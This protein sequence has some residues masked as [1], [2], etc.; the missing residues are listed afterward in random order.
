VTPLLIKVDRV[1]SVD[2]AQVLA[3]LGVQEMTFV[4]KALSQSLEDGRDLTPEE[5]RQAVT[6]VPGVRWG[7]S[8][9]GDWVERVPLE[10]ILLPNLAFVQSRSLSHARDVAVI[11][12]LEFVAEG[13]RADYD[14]DPHW[15][16]ARLSEARRA[17]AN[18]CVVEVYGGLE[19]G[20]AQAVQPENPHDELKESD[21]RTLA[22]HFPF[23]VNANF[24]PEHLQQL[25]GGPYAG[26]NLTLSP[27]QQSFDEVVALFT[28]FQQLQRT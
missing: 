3:G 27:W 7:V 11:P 14:E 10:V 8:I 22:L 5:A 17:G 16:T 1:A 9:P 18:R 23:L 15:V 2:E 28:A 6:A 25:S 20:W 4:P 21:L 19:D 24:R 26:V 13:I 12:T